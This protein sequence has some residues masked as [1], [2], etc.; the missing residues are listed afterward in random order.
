MPRRRRAAPSTIKRYPSVSAV[1]T[2]EFTEARFRDALERAV[3]LGVG[4]AKM[5]D[6]DHVAVDSEVQVSRGGPWASEADA[7]GRWRFS[8]RAERVG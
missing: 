8:F 4:V 6:A 2:T 1:A 7:A 5:A 3:Q